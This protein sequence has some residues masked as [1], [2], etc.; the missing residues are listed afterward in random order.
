MEKLDRVPDDVDI[1]A[2]HGP[3]MGA[4]DRI[5]PSSR[6]NNT[7]ADLRVGDAA[8]AES[9]PRINPMVTICGHIHEGRGE[10]KLPGSDHL[11][12]TSQRWTTTT[13]CTPTRSST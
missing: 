13:R 9:I 7:G 3:P 6:F 1:L 10:E 5:P 11:S 4:G 8:I 2:T 12:S